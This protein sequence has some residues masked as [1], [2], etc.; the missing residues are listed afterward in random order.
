LPI[1]QYLGISDV[2]WRDSS[3]RVEN[4]YYL[5]AWS[6]MNSLLSSQR[7]IDTLRLVLSDMRSNGRFGGGS[8]VEMFDR[9][10]PGGIRKLDRDWRI[11][12]ESRE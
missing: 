10:Y 12:I 1:E 3:A 11:W 7:G 2:Q 6:I 8:L 9:S 5:I 4:T